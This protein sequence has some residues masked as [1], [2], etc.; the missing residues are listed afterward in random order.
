LNDKGG[1]AGTDSFEHDKQVLDRADGKQDDKWRANDIEALQQ[2]FDTPAR[3]A[4]QERIVEKVVSDEGFGAD[5][6][7]DLLYLNFKEIDYVG[8]VWSMNSP[9][10]TDA[11]KYQDAALKRFVPFLNDQVGKG[12]WAMVLTADHAAMPNPDVSGGFEISTGAVSQQIDAKFDTNGDSVS[13]V[14]NVQPG[15]IFLN[16]DEVAANNT[17][18]ADIARFAQTL[19]QAE[20]SGGGVTPNPGQENDPVFQAVFPSSL[21]PDLPCLQKEVSKTSGIV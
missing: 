5:D 11:V 7:P 6:T 12:Q 13:I 1:P 16:E 8:H 18:I 4:Y 21:L 14:D 20:T 15:S 10:M 3:T 2:G 9:E 19:T 17:T